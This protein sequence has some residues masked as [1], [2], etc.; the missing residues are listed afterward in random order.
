[1][2]TNILL[3]SIFILLFCF[4]AVRATDVKDLFLKLPS[5]I[6]KDVDKSSSIVE[7]DAEKSLLKLKFPKDFSGEFKVLS[8]K[9]DETIV[10]LSV[11]SCDESEFEI[12]SFKKGNWQEITDSA[13]P[14]LGKKDV[15]EMLKVSPATVSKL[16][17]AVS[18]PFFYTFDSA[19]SLQLIVRKQSACDIA[20]TVYKYKFNGKKFIKE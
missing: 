19:N 13:A 5:T 16:S 14:K 8:E 1:M 2:K 15:I 3:L 7:T 9:K 11:Y 4:S 6:V 17:E 18:I 10:G 12:W 20:G